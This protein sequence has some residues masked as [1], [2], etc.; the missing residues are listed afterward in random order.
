MKLQIR[1]LIFFTLLHTL[2]LQAFAEERRTYIVTLADEPAA[3]YS[4][5]TQGFAATKPLLGKRFNF[6]ST[7]VQVYVNHLNNQQQ[8]VLDLVK[9]A[10][11]V[12]TYNTVL[13][14]FAASLTEAEVAQ[15]KASKLVKDI[16]VDEIRHLD[17]ISTPQFLQLT[18][19]GGLWSQSVSGGLN[20]GENVVIGIIDGGV[21]PEN[22]AFADRVL[23]GIP[24]H[25]PAGNLVYAAPFAWNGSC[26]NGPGFSAAKHCN[27]K[28]IGAQFFNAGFKATGQVLHWTDFANSPRDSLG[29]VT[30]HG[31]HGTHVASTAGGNENNPVTIGT[32]PFGGASGVAPRARLSTYKVCWTFVDPE[33]EDGTGSTNSCWSSDSVS[34]I[35]KA[36]QDGVN[37]INYSISG[38]QTSVSDPV[39]QA[40]LKATLA[41]VFVAASAGNSG[42]ANR[43]A[44]VSPWLTTVAASTHDR[45]LRAYVTLGNGAQYS[46]ASINT[47][48]VSAR[49][50]VSSEAKSATATTQEANL[51][52]LNSS[53][54]APALDPAKVAGKIVVCTRGTN[55]RVEK[56]AAVLA[57]GGVGMILVDT[58]VGLVAE[59][60]SVPTVHVTAADGAAIKA[61][62]AATQGAGTA[63]IG[64]FY[65]TVK[66]API[67]AGFSSRGPNQGDANL[68]KPDLTAPGV[69]IIAGVTADLT[70]AQKAA[71]VDGTLV[72]P[73]GFASYQGT[74]MSSP[75]VAGLAALLRQAHAD[76]SPT[77]I[78]SALMTTAFS[79]LDDGLAGLQN[80]LLPWAQGAGY[81]APNRATDPGL[82]YDADVLDWVRYLCKVNKALLA[83]PAIC[84]DPAIGTL[85]ETYNLNLPSITVGAVTGTV[86]V[87]RRVTNVS[88]YLSTYTPE[89]VVPE[90]FNVVVTPTALTLAAGETKSFTVKVS[91]VSAPEMV[92]RY[93]SLTWSDGTHL[94]KSPITLRTGKS[95][96]APAL[97]TG[98]TVSGTRLITVN[99]N[100]AGRMTADKGGLV[101][102]T[103]S[104]LASLQPDQLSS[105]DLETA[106]AAGVDTP[107]VKVHKFSVPA[108]TLVARFALRQKDVSNVVDDNDLGVLAPDGQ[109]IYSG[110][111]GSDEEVQL[112]NPVAGEY[113]VCVVAYA[114]GPVMTHK[115]SSWIINPASPITGKFTVLLPSQ[116]YVGGTATVGLSWS[117]LQLQGR[118]LGAVA[119]KD[120]T[121]VRQALTVVQVQTPGS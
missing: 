41:G 58:G 101:N 10:P 18:A 102:V 119:F 96:L 38:S 87:V 63:S 19:P 42:P 105:D 30:G 46:G 92:W 47:S 33:A 49:L 71:L 1:S 7:A 64:I 73:A 12:A 108:G 95:I 52:F 43:V 99:T 107:A 21:W 40:F 77:A 37:V 110:N 112:L 113:K 50:I 2:A 90:G 74:S 56:S 79:T 114:G 103:L 5:G 91:A 28:L 57:A 62:V 29:G 82:V 67:I 60:H 36:I 34:A 54:G 14:G 84:A 81:V 80:G 8:D 3:S 13:N 51:C 22:P 89:I 11:V 23:A 118:Y 116:V 93:G 111:S 61:Y 117:G 98:N 55:A 88:G 66:P 20:K 32:T 68:L 86:A 48:P 39:E 65:K 44:H 76:W 4:G 120:L 70:L 100:F 83:N 31:G 94:V 97:I 106:C 104:G 25:K 24:T 109:F 27:N 85:D 45:D 115:L 17:T 9:G 69:D 53:T 121:G 59:Q 75:H 35:E 6:Q 78:K 72:P 26:V 15:L 16:Q